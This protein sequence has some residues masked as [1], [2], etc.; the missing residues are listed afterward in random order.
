[1]SKKYLRIIAHYEN[2]LDRYGDTHRGVDWP[3]EEDVDTRYQVMLEVMEKETGR[4]CSLLDLGCGTSHLYEYMLKQGLSTI[5]Y[6]GLDL[7]GKFIEVAKKKF[8]ENSYYCL[9]L[10]D[11]NIT[12]PVFDYVVMNGVFTEKRELAYE[13]MLLYFKDMIRKVFAHTRVG[14]AFNVMSKQVDWER[15][16]LFHLPLDTLAGF[17]TREI[18]RNFV[19]R[20]DYGLYEYTTYIYR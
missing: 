18:S 7:S 10:L 8:P 11:T 9:D 6:S 4:Q 20:N 17:L 2:C 16:D 15:D 3:K 5:S 12:L 14:M 13:E 1:M 19:I